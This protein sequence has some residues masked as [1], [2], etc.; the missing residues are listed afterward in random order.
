MKLGNC[1]CE[2]Q[3]QPN[4]IPGGAKGYTLVTECEPC[5][6]KREENNAAQA[7]AERIKNLPEN[8]FDVRLFTDRLNVSF[9]GLELIA[10]APYYAVLKDQAA[11]PSFES[12]KVTLNALK[13]ATILSQEGYDKI[14]AIL[15]E[16]NIDLSVF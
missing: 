3:E 13:D 1:D 7:E 11:F 6:I 12:V 16:Q 2:W 9:S 14:A 5:R 10:L 8:K 4:Q 15:L